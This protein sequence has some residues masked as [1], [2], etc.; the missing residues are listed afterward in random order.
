M[1]S[2]AQIATT[3]VQAAPL[4]TYSVMAIEYFECL[5]FC[6]LLVFI[7][8]LVVSYGSNFLC[9]HKYGYAHGAIFF[10]YVGEPDIY[11]P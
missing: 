4:Y 1:R 8:R 6:K 7:T 10:S 9:A 5:T 11:L 3:A 2:V